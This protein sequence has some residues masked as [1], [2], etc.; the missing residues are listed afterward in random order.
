MADRIRPVHSS[1]RP[2]TRALT[3]Q[4]GRSFSLLHWYL[5]DH[6]FVIYAKPVHPMRPPKPA[7][8]ITP[9]GP[10]RTGLRGTADQ[11]APVLPGLAR[12]FPL[13]APLS[14]CAGVSVRS[15]DG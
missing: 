12:R 2:R 9:I 7:R 10:P 1:S 13:F 4:F 8:L 5:R 3:L 14:S 11:F 15:R 6:E